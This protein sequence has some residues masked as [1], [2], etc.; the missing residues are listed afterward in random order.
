MGETCG[1][2]RKLIRNWRIVEMELWDPEDVDL[3]GPAFIEFR[4]NGQGEF[5]FIAVRGF[6]DVRHGG[7]DGSRSR[8][9]RGTATTRVIRRAV[10]GG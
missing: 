2:S 6:M 10:A 5:Q 1:V 8:S 9:S 3:V 7:R 4:A